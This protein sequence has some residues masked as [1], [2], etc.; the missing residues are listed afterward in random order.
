MGNR[1]YFRLVTSALQKKIVAQGLD[2]EAALD[3]PDPKAALEAL[4]DQL[5]VQRCNN[6]LSV[7]VHS[8]RAKAMQT[9]ALVAMAVVLP[10]LQLASMQTSFIY[11]TQ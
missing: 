6:T 9:H 4:L 11:A 1:Y 10:R 7:D 8:K 5:S 3:S 2:P